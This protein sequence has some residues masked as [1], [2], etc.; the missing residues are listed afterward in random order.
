MPCWRLRD[1]VML[2][3]MPFLPTWT[4]SPA[5]GR[6]PSRS[7][8]ATWRPLTS[9]T[10]VS[11]PHSLLTCC[12][13]GYLLRDLFISEA[14]FQKVEERQKSNMGVILVYSGNGCNSQ[15]LATPKLG[16]R[17]SIWLSHMDERDLSTWVSCCCLTRHVDR[18]L[19]RKQRS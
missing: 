1:Q 7:S 14:E 12:F 5:V 15:G 3:S 19:G 13:R 18:K 16:A 2:P 8:R 11:D 9:E 4:P 10:W 17:N 6:P